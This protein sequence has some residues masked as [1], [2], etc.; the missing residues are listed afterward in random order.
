MSDMALTIV[1]VD[2]NEHNL[3][4]EMDL[5]EVAGFNVH[6]ARNGRA[7]LEVIRRERPDIVVLD[8]R[9]PDM[10]GVD[11]ALIL[12]QEEDTRGIPIVF[13]TASVMADGKDLIDTIPRSG[14][15][16]KPI[17]TRTFVAEVLACQGFP[18]KSTPIH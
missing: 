13:V 16:G 17:N 6:G 10:S 11:V 9:L 8:V 2:D 14:F 3:E 18:H 12:R 15:I 7:A 4:L 5:F 1:V